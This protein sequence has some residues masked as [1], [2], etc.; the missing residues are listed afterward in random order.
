M[1]RFPNCG[2]T[3]IVLKILHNEKDQSVDET[4]I[5]G[6]YEKKKKNCSGQIGNFG[7]E[8]GIFS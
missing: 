4:N 1:V 5:N 2:F 7:P 8:K 6:F 3:L